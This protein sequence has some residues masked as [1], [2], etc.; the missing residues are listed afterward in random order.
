MPP[1]QSGDEGMINVT[2]EKMS[3]ERGITQEMLRE[4]YV[5]DTATAYNFAAL[6]KNQEREMAAALARRKII[7]EAKASAV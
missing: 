6:E 4:K 3:K 2:E 5:K 1:L 7:C